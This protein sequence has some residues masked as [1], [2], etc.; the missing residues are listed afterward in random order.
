MTTLLDRLVG[1]HPSRSLPVSKLHRTVT[2]LAVISL[3]VGTHD[4]WAAE[5]WLHPTAAGVIM[6]GYGLMLLCGVA[7]LAVQ[8]LRIMVGV[9]IAVLAVALV[10]R[11]PIFVTS[12][13]PGS[14]SYGNDEGQLVDYA[15]NA[16]A[17]GQDPYALI[18]NGAYARNQGGITLTMDGRIIDKY[19]YPPVSA[20]LNY[21]LRPVSFGVPTAA[22]VAMLALIAAMIVMFVMVPAPWRSAAVLVCFGLNLL[23]PLARNGYPSMVA[24]PLVIAAV[25]SWT[26]IGTGR[27]AVG[28]LDRRG[29]ISAICLG[30]A[31]STQPLPW[32]I[33]PFLIVG[34]FLIRYGDL[35]ARFAAL[36]T[37]HYTGVVLLVA[38]AVNVPFM[39]WNYQAWYTGVLT[40]LTE[41]TVPHGQGLIGISYYL[42]GGSGAMDYYAYAAGLLVIGLLICYA[43]FIRRIGPAMVILPWTVFYLS[44][45]SQDIYFLTMTPIWIMSVAT[46][47]HADFARAWQLPR[48]VL[49][50]R[51]LRHWSVAALTAALLLAPAAI[52]VNIAVTTPQPLRMNLVGMIVSKTGYLINVLEVDVTNTS[53]VPIEPHFALSNSESMSHFLTADTGP[54]LLAPK[55]TALY[56]LLPWS[57]GSR[58]SLADRVVLRAVSANPVTLSSLQLSFPNQPS[59]AGNGK[60]PRHAL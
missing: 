46:T 23:P 45:R 11:L 26:R 17:H 59:P 24:L 27:V 2:V 60:T 40:P 21:L 36:L 7:A 47:S 57:P 3:F 29:W 10:V 8:S 43:L 34:I 41:P 6:V 15:G 50:W 25:A 31:I 52:C 32:F 56:V 39:I 28:W 16:L 30:L 19:D 54:A 35:G 51:P 20:V 22:L 49:R 44:I 13:A 58:R 33:A 38:A 18:W 5:I 53:D 12:Y 14:P 37:A 4:A 9:D 55:Q 42:V 48:S 1:R